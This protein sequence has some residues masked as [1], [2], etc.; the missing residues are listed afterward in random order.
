MK[1]KKPKFWDYKKKNFFSYLMQPFTLPILLNNFFL[2]KKNKKLSKNIKSICIGNIYVGGTGKTPLVAKL[3]NLL[4]KKIKNI[5][6]AKK[7]YQSQIDEIKL[8]EKKTNLIHSKSRINLIDDAI[9]KNNQ[10]IIFDDGLQD[11]NIDYN[12][13]FVCF[14]AMTWIG[15]GQ[16]IPA[17]PLR[18]NLNSLKKYHAIFLNNYDENMKDIQDKLLLINPKL[19]IFKSKYFIKNIDRLD[20][21]SKYLIFSGIGNPQNFK[22]IL[23][24][25]NFK[26]VNEIKFPDHY[27]YLK[28]DLEKIIDIAIK[29]NLKILTTE[30]DYVKISNNFKSKIGY[31]EIDLDLLNETE[32][33]NYIENKLNE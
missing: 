20:K 23:E 14:D 11:K 7:F 2:N 21:E 4:N 25:S 10:I 29:N 16:I 22:K 8:L 27:N 9:K 15:N 28:S 3:Y 31:V 12:L 5:V 33:I 32:I 17:G 30:K 6:V 18:E 1:L 24:N 26:I 19:K 13:K